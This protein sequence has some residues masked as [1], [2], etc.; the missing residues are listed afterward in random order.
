MLMHLTPGSPGASFFGDRVQ[1][2]V[3]TSELL[4]LLDHIPLSSGTLQL[5][6]ENVPLRN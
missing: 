2:V 3:M 5:S 6:P 1:L 4:A